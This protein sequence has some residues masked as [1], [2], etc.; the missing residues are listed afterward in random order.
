MLDL[1]IS[2]P[3]KSFFSGKVNRVVL[4][5]DQGEFEIRK[6]HIAIMS[7]LQTGSILAFPESGDPIAFCID[8]GLVHVNKNRVSVLVDTAFKARLNEKEKLLAEQRECRN[9]LN[10]TDKA[11]YN[12]LMKK[13][14]ELSTE[15]NAINR[16]R[17]NRK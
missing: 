7:L 11:D 15:L 6:N 5:G 1:H 17:K 3:E 8:S 14:T 2:S 4:P 12:T 16:I 10:K 9:K 13:L